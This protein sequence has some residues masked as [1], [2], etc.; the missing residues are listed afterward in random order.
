MGNVIQKKSHEV[1][2]YGRLHRVE[3]G[4]SIWPDEWIGPTNLT[5]SEWD[6]A[7]F[8][9][10]SYRYSEQGVATPV[11]VRVT[12]RTFQRRP[13]S[14]RYWV[15]VQIEFIQDSR[16]ITFSAGWASLEAVP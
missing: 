9:L 2:I 10:P 4:T 3:V 1:Q 5:A 7:E 6:G 11:N 15:R 14:D 13:F 16:E 8:Y 12:G